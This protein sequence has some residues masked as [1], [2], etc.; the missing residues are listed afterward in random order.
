MKRRYFFP[1]F[2]FFGLIGSLFFNQFY[3]FLAAGQQHPL[4]KLPKINSFKSLLDVRRFLQQPLAYPE[5]E[6]FVSGISSGNADLT[7]KQVW[8]TAINDNLEAKDYAEIGFSSIGLENASS[9]LWTGVTVSANFDV[10]MVQGKI[11]VGIRVYKDG[12][13][14]TGRYV[15]QNSSGQYTVKTDPFVMEPGHKYKAT[16]YIGCYP[17]NQQLSAGIGKILEIKWTI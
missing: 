7:N 8:A 2:L 14:F 16:A 9:M 10:T 1:V 15:W 6:I 12:G 11:Q 3:G 13:N 17:E 5:K 4:P